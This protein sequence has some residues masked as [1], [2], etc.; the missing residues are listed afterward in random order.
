VFDQEVYDRSVHRFDTPELTEQFAFALLDLVTLALAPLGLQRSQGSHDLFVDIGAASLGSFGCVLHD[1]LRFLLGVGYQS[2][3]CTLVVQ[4]RLERRARARRL[5]RC[6][7]ADIVVG[8][9][10]SATRR[11][12]IGDFID[13]GFSAQRSVP[14]H[15]PACSRDAALLRIPLGKSAASRATHVS[16]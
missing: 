10:R 15:A 7:P 11:Q 14:G 1:S 13:N 9:R 5:R 4:N 16:G 3:S 2:G 8:W 6:R 12:A